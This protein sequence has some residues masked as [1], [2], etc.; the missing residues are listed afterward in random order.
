[1]LRFHLHHIVCS[2]PHSLPT[3]GALSWCDGAPVKGIR[4]VNEDE[5]FSLSTALLSLPSNEKRKYVEK[6]TTR[7]QRSLKMLRMISLNLIRYDFESAVCMYQQFADASQSEGGF[8]QLKTR[9]EYFSLL[10]I[11]CNLSWE[12]ELCKWYSTR[13]MLALIKMFIDQLLHFCHCQ[14]IESR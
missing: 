12:N 6:K 4:D 8:L 9:W 10:S 5:I 2:Y 11:A 1:M 3:F 7:R 14:L 13:T